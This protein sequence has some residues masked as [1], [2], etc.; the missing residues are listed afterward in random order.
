[1]TDTAADRA[2]D[3]AIDSFRGHLAAERGLAAATLA[4]YERDLQGLRAWTAARGGLAPAGLTADDLRAYLAARAKELAPRSRARLVSTLRSF[5]RFLAAQRWAPLTAAAPRQGPRSGRPLP[6]VLTVAQVERLLAAVTGATPRDLRD[7]A[8]LEILYGCGLR[9]S[10][11]CGINVPDLDPQ[12]ATLRVRGKGSKVRVVPVGQPALAA[13]SAWLSEGRPRLLGRRPTAALLL[14]SRGGRLSR[15]SIWQLLQR[16]ARAAD[17]AGRISPHTL[18]HSYATHLLEGGCDL[19]I[20]QELL[21]HADLATTEIYTHVDRA[22]L[23]EAY[24]SAQPR[25]RGGPRSTL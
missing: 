7:R 8:V 18:R 11:C 15:V 14:N 13:A 23:R 6:N 4:A 25:A 3:Q 10:E 20:V 24:R 16:C 5:C 17:L 19:R 2:W 12:A 22:F 21:G 1:M 9:V